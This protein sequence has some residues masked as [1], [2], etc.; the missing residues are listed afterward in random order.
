[1]IIHKTP[2]HGVLMMQPELIEDQR[3]FFARTF[4]RQQFD[5]LGLQT[6]I[7]QCSFAVNTRSGTL[8]GLH[9]QRPPYGEV[10]WVRCTKGAVCDVLVDL[11]PDS[12]TYARWTAIELTE[13]N[14]ST[15]YIPEYVAHGYQSLTPESELFYQ[16]SQFY[17]PEYAW[18]IRWND[19][20]FNISWPLPVSC[21]SSKDQSWPDFDVA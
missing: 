11:R 7:A 13:Q 14:R 12:P 21:I 3:G 20:A 18:G 4:C 15:L 1:M 9:F 8:R 16:I 6:G 17:N 10:K 5:D 2:L 19:P